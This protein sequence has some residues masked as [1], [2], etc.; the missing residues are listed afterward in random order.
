MDAT[1]RDARSG[2]T[3]DMARTARIRDGPRLRLNSRGRPFP[4][5]R[6][7]LARA[8]SSAV[9]HCL[10][11]AGVAGSNPAPPTTAKPSIHAASVRADGQR[12]S[13]FSRTVR[14][15]YG[16]PPA[17]FMLRWSSLQPPLPTSPHDARRQMFTAGRSVRSRPGALHS[18]LPR[19]GAADRGC[20]G[21]SLAAACCGSGSSG[22]IWST[23]TGGRGRDLRT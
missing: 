9:E 16:M 20:A 7:S 19:S 11:T 18:R 5:R 8:V 17:R 23:V 22:R 13:G 12:G 21:S 1:E 14:K 6:F 2:E 10:H 3:N 4:G 15:L